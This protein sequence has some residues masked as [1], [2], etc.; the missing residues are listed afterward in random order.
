MDVNTDCR[1]YR[2]TLWTVVLKQKPCTSFTFASYTFIPVAPLG[3]SVR[4]DTLAERYER[5]MNRIEQIAHA[6]Y[7][8]KIQWEYE[9]DE[10]KIVEERPEF[11]THPIV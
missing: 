4:R 9:F 1:K 8:V 11:M 2:F 6:W 5:T 7:K 3:I 10:S